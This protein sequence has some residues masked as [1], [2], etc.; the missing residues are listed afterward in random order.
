MRTLLI[1]MLALC[2]VVSLNGCGYDNLYQN[3]NN[4][5]EHDDDKSIP[6]SNQSSVRSR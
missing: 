2:A 1:L 6:K 3:Y 4:Y 5:H